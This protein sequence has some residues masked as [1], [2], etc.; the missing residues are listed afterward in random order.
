M[1]QTKNIFRELVRQWFHQKV[2]VD[3]GKTVTFKEV[4]HDFQNFLESKEDEITIS[5]QAFSLYFYDLLQ[6]DT[7]KIDVIRI[8]RKNISFFNLGLKDSNIF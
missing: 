1:V 3:K 2:T 8:K 4:F 5:K 6:Q 7:S